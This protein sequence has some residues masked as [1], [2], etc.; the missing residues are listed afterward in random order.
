MYVLDGDVLY[1]GNIAPA[2]SRGGGGVVIYF[3]G[4]SNIPAGD[5]LFHVGIQPL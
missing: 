2:V 5:I 1:Q 4:G 3:R